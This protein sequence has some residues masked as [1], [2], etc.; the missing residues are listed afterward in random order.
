ME[1]GLRKNART[2]RPASSTPPPAASFCPRLRLKLGALPPGPRLCSI[3]RGCAEGWPSG[4]SWRRLL[5][6]SFVKSLQSQTEPDASPALGP[7]CSDVRLHPP[8]QGPA[9]VGVLRRGLGVVRRRPRPCSPC[10][11]ARAVLLAAAADAA[12][13]L[14]VQERAAVAERAPR[15][16]SLSQSSMD[17]APCP[18]RTSARSREAALAAQRA[19]CW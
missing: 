17:R 3:G 11:T 2:Q 8:L 9:G 15:W 19:R 13:A 14:R 18:A 7:G 16:N 6:G 1:E 4:L 10:R 12:V 5:P